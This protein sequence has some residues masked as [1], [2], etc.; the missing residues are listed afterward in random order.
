MFFDLKKKKVWFFSYS[1]HCQTFLL[2]LHCPKVATSHMYLL[3]FN[4]KS[5]NIKQIKNLGF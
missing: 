4:L 3:K 2:I 1:V 5:V